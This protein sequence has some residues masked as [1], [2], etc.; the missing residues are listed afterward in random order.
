MNAKDIDRIHAAGLIS[1]D[2]RQ[3]IFTHF[4]LGD[5]PNRL[6]LILS[7]IGGIMVAAGLILVMAANWDRIPELA[8]IIS[9]LGLM[10]GCHLGGW[11]LRQTGRFHAAS[12]GLNLIGSLL[13]L[14]NIALLGQVFNLSSRPQ[15]AILLWLVGIAPTAFLLRSKPQHVLTL[16][17]ATVWLGYETFHRE[18]WFHLTGADQGGWLILLLGANAFIALGVWLKRDAFGPTT[19]KHGLLLV[20]L[21]SLPLAWPF[22]L[23]GTSW[24]SSELWM[25]LVVSVAIGGL[26][27]LGIWRH[28]TELPMQWRVTWAATLLGVWLLGW[29]A[30]LYGD[31]WDTHRHD[32]HPVS[33]ATSIGL[34]IFCLVQIQAGLLR[35]SPWLVNLAL[36]FIAAHLITAYVKL[37]GTMLTTGTVFIVGG[38]FLVALAIYLEKKRRQ[39]LA[40]MNTTTASPQ[41]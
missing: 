13:F 5:A 8:K 33:W 23:D 15:N 22:F 20:H 41:P 4:R 35:R 3:A 29:L 16:L 2:Q 11:W 36:V 1:D 18:G 34:F 40:Q 10:V 26:L 6:L 32:A 14:G 21:V 37:F 30:L 9:G 12:E 19:E 31:R 27:F 7:I 28:Q 38:A 24:Q 39:L 25:A 17:A